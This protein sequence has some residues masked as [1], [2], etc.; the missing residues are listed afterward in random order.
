[1]SGC[2]EGPSPQSVEGQ[3]RLWN[4]DEDRTGSPPK[5]S[6]V[7][8]GTWEVR[9]EPGAPTEPN[10]VC[11]TGE[12]KFPALVLGDAR[13]MDLA[14]STEFKPVSGEED[15]AAGLIFR[16]QD[17]DN[18]YIARANALEDNVAIY[19]YSGGERSELASAPVRIDPT[20]AGEWRELR[21]E[22]DG[23]R[24]RVLLDLKEVIE[25]TDDEFGAGRVGL[26]TKAD[27]VSCFD[28]VLAE[29]A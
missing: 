21:V 10:A 16:L 5:G 12:A 25:A 2:G 15:R 23:N 27:S 7:F 18:Y 26:W 11:Q 6:E 13:Y 3:Q 14:L 22:V 4:F 1:M 8:A 19:K 29:A 28:K 9:R 24:I 17:E 20:E